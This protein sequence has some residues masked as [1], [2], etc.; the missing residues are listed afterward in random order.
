MPY[1]ASSPT[2]QCLNGSPGY[3]SASDYSCEVVVSWTACG[4]CCRAGGPASTH[5]PTWRKVR[6]D[7]E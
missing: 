7:G 4:T 1:R 2:G 5:G 3:G 6:T